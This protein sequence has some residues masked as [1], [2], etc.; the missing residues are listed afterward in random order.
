MKEVIV[1]FIED[2]TDRVIRTC[3]LEEYKSD[4]ESINNLIPEEYKFLKKNVMKK[5]RINLSL[6]TDELNV[7]VEE[8]YTTKRMVSACMEGEQEDDGCVDELTTKRYEVLKKMCDKFETAYLKTSH[9]HI[10]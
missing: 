5:V 8:L 10:D 7:F 3:P 4:I 1:E 2:G 6:S 9:E